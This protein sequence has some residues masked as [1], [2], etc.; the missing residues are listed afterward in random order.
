MDVAFHPS[1]GTK[2]IAGDRVGHA[3][4]STDGGQSF[5][6]ASGLPSGAQRVELAYARSDPSIV[7]ASVNYSN[8]V[9]YRSIDGGHTFAAT[10][11]SN[12]LANTYANVLWVDPTN[13]KTLVFGGT[14]IYRSTDGGNT[15]TDIGGQC[16]SCVHIDDHVVINDPNYNGSSNKKAY[17]GTDGGIFS[18]Q[19]ILA[20]PVV[21]TS[22]NHTLAITQFY[23][24]AGNASS[25]TIIGGT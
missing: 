22:L 13:S 12:T 20:S 18:T 11:A 15:K 10:A 23:G 19:D 25:G 8:G 21:W 6:Q 7:Y 24:G 3:Y 5:S 14:V 1:D 2:C 4:Y 9:L 16:P 17:C